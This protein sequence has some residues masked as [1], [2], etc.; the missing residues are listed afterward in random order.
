MDLSKFK[1]VKAGN[2][3]KKSFT[4]NNLNAA[5]DFHKSPYSKGV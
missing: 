4:N 2:S 3:V 1:F 5:I